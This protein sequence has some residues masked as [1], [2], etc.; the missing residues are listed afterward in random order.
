MLDWYFRGFCDELSPRLKYIQPLPEKPVYYMAQ[1]DMG[2]NPEWPIRVNVE[3]G[4]TLHF[5]T[6]N[7]EKDSEESAIRGIMIYATK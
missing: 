3:H 1:R 7:G 2:F 4:A 6:S 5:Y